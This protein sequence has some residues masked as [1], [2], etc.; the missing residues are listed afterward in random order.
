MNHWAFVT[1]AYVITLG[2]TAAL[3]GWSW[4]AMQDAERDRK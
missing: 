1:A 4:F 2:A 3:V